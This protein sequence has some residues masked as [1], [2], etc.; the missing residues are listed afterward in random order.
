MLVKIFTP[1]FDG[2]EFVR[3]ISTFKFRGDLKL[4][5]YGE[6][7]IPLKV[8]IGSEGTIGRWNTCRESHH[9]VNL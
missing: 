5:A 8:D 6:T 2:K 4:E 1:G 9:F 7:I 3:H